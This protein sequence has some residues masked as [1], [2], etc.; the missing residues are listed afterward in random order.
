MEPVGPVLLTYLALAIVRNKKMKR[1]SRFFMEMSA[2]RHLL[3]D[4]G[5]FESSGCF[6]IFIFKTFDSNKR[7]FDP[8]GTR[9]G[10]SYGGYPTMCRK[11][12]EPLLILMLFNVMQ[13]HCLKTSPFGDVNASWRN[14]FPFP[15]LSLS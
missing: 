8:V 1:N 12:P 5:C 9:V 13:C 3:I 14:L 6:F 2:R 15:L 4:I 11:I 10:F 7:L